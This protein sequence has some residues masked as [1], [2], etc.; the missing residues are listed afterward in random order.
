MKKI[1]KIPAFTLTEVLV[2]I[3]ISVI[4]AG[5]AFSVLEIVQNNFSSIRKNFEQATKFDHLNEKLTIDFNNYQRIELDKNQRQIWFRNPLD[6]ISYRYIEPY[7]FSDQDTIKVTE[8]KFY[9][10]GNK[11]DEGKVDAVKIYINPDSY[12]FIF[13]KNDIATYLR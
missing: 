6:S 5:L 10:M 2:V 9:F 12:I 11:V 8:L 4:V 13:K 7:L 3:V 1:R